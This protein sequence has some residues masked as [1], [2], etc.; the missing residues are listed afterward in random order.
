MPRK[1]LIETSQAPYHITNRSN[2]REQFYVAREELWFV[3]MDV[4]KEMTEQFHC[5]LQSFVL[6]SN[7]YHLMVST[8]K[9][10]I[11]EAMKYLHREVAR[12]ANRSAG[13]TN[14]FFGGR[15]KWT[16]VY[17]ETYFWNCTKYL[18]R[19]PIRAGMC[20]KVEQ[21]PFSSYNRISPDFNWQLTDFFRDPLNPIILDKDWLNEPML[22][23]TEEAI[24]RGLRRREFQ[25]HRTP[26][27]KG[28]ILDKPQYRKG[29]VT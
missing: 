15:Y 11:G 13:R 10:N 17:D 22:S 20:E 6:M 24:R 19:N 25:L 14:H 23:E 21:Y 7:H 18:F 8:P 1:L 4:F 9:R 2:N 12:K 16:V 3:F 26:R 29:T 5:N 28:P 27:G